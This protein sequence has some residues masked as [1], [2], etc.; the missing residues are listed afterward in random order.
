[1][2]S[3]DIS[4][5]MYIRSQEEVEVDNLRNSNEKYVFILEG[6]SPDEYTPEQ[7]SMIHAGH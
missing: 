2:T 1:M 3:D 5:I 4:N 7:I 6:T